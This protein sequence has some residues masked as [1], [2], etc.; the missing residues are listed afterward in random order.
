MAMRILN[1]A[2]VTAHGNEEGRRIVAQIMEAGL[3]AADPY[4]MP[5]AFLYV[6]ATC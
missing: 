6:R 3:Q 4:Q 2:Q 5:A 1:M